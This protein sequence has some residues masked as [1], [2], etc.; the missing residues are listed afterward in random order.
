MVYKSHDLPGGT[1]DISVEPLI[2]RVACG[3][4]DYYGNY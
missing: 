2:S 3:N 4:Y 1:N